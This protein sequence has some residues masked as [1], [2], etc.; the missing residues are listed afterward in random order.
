MV[1][2]WLL[3]TLI[4]FDIFFFLDVGNIAKEGGNQDKYHADGDVDVSCQIWN[5][6][7]EDVEY[8]RK[9]KYQ[10]DNGNKE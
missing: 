2:I 5:A 6:F 8:C 4:F 3:N 1:F 7:S 10:T 9:G